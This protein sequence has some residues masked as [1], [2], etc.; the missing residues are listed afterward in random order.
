MLHLGKR[1]GRWRK[2]SLLV[3]FPS[4]FYRYV[5]FTRHANLAKATAVAFIVISL[6]D[7]LTGS[8]QML[9]A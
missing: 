9:T 4:F 2:L 6:L 1:R 5:G 8:Y 3:S 7:I